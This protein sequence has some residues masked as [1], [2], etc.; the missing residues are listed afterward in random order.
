M[1]APQIFLV[2]ELELRISIEA[3]E[4][5]HK[6]DNFWEEHKFDPEYFNRFMEGPLLSCHLHLLFAWMKSSQQ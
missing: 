4:Y 6:F 5:K 1:N 2:E 3:V